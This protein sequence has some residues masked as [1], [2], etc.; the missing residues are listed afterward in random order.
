MRRMSKNMTQE[1][2]ILNVHASAPGLTERSIGVARTR[3]GATSYEAFCDFAKPGEGMSVVDLAC[4]NGPLTELLVRRVGAGGRVSA[5]DL[6]EAELNSARVRLA[7]CP[8][9][10]FLNE[11]ATH[12]SL[13]SE[14][15]DLIVCHMAFMLFTPLGAA[16]EELARVL[17]HGGKFAAVI[18]TLRKP[19]ALFAA[20]AAELKASLCAE[21]LEREAI[22]GNGVRMGDV[23]DL[24][25]IFPAGQW[26]TDE[27]I[28]TE[29]IEV[30]VRAAPEELLERVEPAF[31]SF[32]L[33][34][35][36]GRLRLRDR[37]LALFQ[38]AKDGT[39]TAAFEFPLTAFSVLRR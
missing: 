14:T 19:S 31:Y 16:V 30:A 38:A 34:P 26:R 33:L 29:A 13:P 37:W 39:G 17:K 6:S 27:G 28:V 23:D 1:N 20:C 24:K 32:R 12:L 18:P 2:F 7:R 21:G 4:G 35:E 5:V 8:G 10:Q 9:V 3:A 15:A 11:A 22:S 36:A 25:R